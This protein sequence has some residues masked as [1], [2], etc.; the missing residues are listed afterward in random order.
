VAGVDGCAGGWMVV[1]AG[2][3]LQASVVPDLAPLVAQVRAGTITLVAI[4][5]P[6]GLLDTSPRRCDVE[7]RALLGPRGASV[8][9]AP[10]RAA[11]AATSY[12][13]ACH[14]S[15]AAT[16]KALSKQTYFLLDRIRRLDELL[17]PEDGP[18][19]VEAHPELA[20]ARLAG[21]P[22]LSKH[23]PGGR[24]QR[25]DLLDRELGRPFDELAGR[26]APLGDL[27]DAAVLTITARRALDGTATRLGGEV[28]GTGKT[29]EIVY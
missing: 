20:F 8:F 12:R 26:V 3:G 24:Q 15:Q 21:G 13:D 19:V 16:G 10:V 25:L 23:S 1:T 17:G 11:L 2:A 9:P 29:A 27:L 14:R 4:D 7:A 22:L 18:L 6:I 28:D 5:L